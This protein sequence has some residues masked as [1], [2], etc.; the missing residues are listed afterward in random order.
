MVECGHQSVVQTG[1]GNLQ[2]QHAPGLPRCDLQYNQPQPLSSPIVVELFTMVSLQ[3]VRVA[4]YVRAQDIELVTELGSEP[5]PIIRAIHFA[6]DKC[7]V[8]DKMFALFMSKF[9][10]LKAFS[11]W[12]T[13]T[14]AHLSILCG[15]RCDLQELDVRS[16][17]YLSA[18][19]VADMIS[20]VAH[21]IVTLRCSSLDDQA[22]IALSRLSFP[23]LRHLQLDC[24]CIAHSES[25]AA[26]CAAIS[27][28]LE[29]LD[30]NSDSQCRVA[31]KA[32]P[33]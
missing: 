17:P 19:A 28:T 24:W 23:M 9:P 25:I 26:W 31:K 21:S 30:L 20:S 2:S 18:T 7:V 6:G 8:D 14:D 32:T 29:S 12:W 16:C 4:L 13:M 5:F 1:C 27:S 22:L 11:G 15:W 33:S 10:S 3:K